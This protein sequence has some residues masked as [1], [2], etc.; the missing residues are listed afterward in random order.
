MKIQELLQKILDIAMQDEQP[1]ETGLEPEIETGVFMPPLQTNIELM[2]KA[3]GEPHQLDAEQGDE[4]DGDCGCG[5]DYED[6]WQELA[7]EPEEDPL[8]AIRHLAGLSGETEHPTALLIN[9]STE[10]RF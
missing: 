4:E 1:E 9:Q 5:G 2:K 8:Q 10:P 7:A 6:E 3:A